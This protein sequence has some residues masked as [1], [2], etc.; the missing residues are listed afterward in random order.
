MKQHSEEEE[1]ERL[2]RDPT[3][4]Q[5]GHQT[6]GHRCQLQLLAQHCCASAQSST[7]ARGGVATQ[8]RSYYCPLTTNDVRRNGSAATAQASGLRA[9]PPIFAVVMFTGLDAEAFAVARVTTSF[10][11]AWVVPV[12]IVALLWKI[13]QKTKRQIYSALFVLQAILLGGA[14]Y[15]FTYQYGVLHLAEPIVSVQR[16]RL[17]DGR[18]S[19]LLIEEERAYIVN[20]RERLYRIDLERG[21]KGFIARIPMPEPAEVGLPHLMFT[22][23]GRY[24]NPYVGVLNRVDDD[25]LFLRFRYRLT[26]GDWTMGVRIHEESGRVD[27]QLL[28]KEHDVPIE[29]LSSIFSLNPVQAVPPG[30]RVTTLTPDQ[31]LPFTLLVESEGVRTAIDPLGMVTWAHAN[32]G[33]ILVGTNRGG[34]IIVTT[35]DR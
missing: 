24:D 5:S 23:R 2:S 26:G 15:Y 32:H 29:F 19:L 35:K 21:R 4:E 30:G 3:A 10:H 11:I 27:W 20:R 1:H 12:V 31:R 33:W 25:E 9:C 34:L 6:E 13:D 28:G 7:S 17:G 22:R 14:I 16:L 8:R 18:L